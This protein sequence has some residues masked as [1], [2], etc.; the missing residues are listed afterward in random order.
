MTTYNCTIEQTVK[1]EFKDPEKAKEVYLGDDWKSVFCEYEDL[2]EVAE[3]LSYA[4]G[5]E[6]GEW[7]TETRRTEQ[8]VEGFGAFVWGGG[9]VFELSPEVEEGGG[10]IVVTFGDREVEVSNA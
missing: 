2:S 10:E 4:M 6:E 9:G 1:V 3:H 8:Y 7:N 5:A